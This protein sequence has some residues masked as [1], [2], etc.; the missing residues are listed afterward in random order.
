MVCFRV[1]WSFHWV[2]PHRQADVWRSSRTTIDIVAV[3][4]WRRGWLLD[5]RKAG[6]REGVAVSGVGNVIVIPGLGKE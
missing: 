6:R 2:L 1:C 5:W 4:V 3:A